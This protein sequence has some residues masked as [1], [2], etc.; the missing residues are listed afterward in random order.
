[1]TSL[2]RH[3]VF[4]SL[5]ICFLASTVGS[6]AWAIP[7]VTLSANLNELN[8][9]PYLGSYEDKESTENIDTIQHR[10][11]AGQFTFSNTENLNFGYTHSAYWL[12]TSIETHSSNS[13]LSVHRYVV[14]YDY[15]PIDFVDLFVLRDGQLEHHFTEGDQQ[16]TPNVSQRYRL[17]AFHLQLQPDQEY[18]LVFRISG[19]GS[20]QAPIS[21]W[22]EDSF[23]QSHTQ[24]LFFWGAFYG[25]L[26]VMLFYNSL[27]YLTV[28]SRSYLYYIVY[29]FAF[30]VFQSGFAGHSKMGLPPYY[31]AI[32]TQ[33]ILTGGWV[34]I[35]TINYFTRAFLQT[36]AHSHWAHLWLSTVCWLGT[37]LS[38][39][40]LF[41]SY[42]VNS[43]LLSL[44][45]L[46]TAATC[47]GIAIRSIYTGM[48]MATS[49][50]W[51]W[52]PFLVALVAEA[53]RN[54][55]LLPI[56]IITQNPLQIGSLLQVVM[57]SL[58]LAER[59][60]LS[61]KLREQ[62]LETQQSTE[63]KLRLREKELH[64]NAL[65]DPISGLPNKAMVT[66]AF[67]ENV[68]FNNK[69]VACILIFST[70]FQTV[71][72]TLGHESAEE[73][74]RLAA[75]RLIRLTRDLTDS[76]PIENQDFHPIRIASIEG[77]KFIVLMQLS[78]QEDQVRNFCEQVHEVLNSP[79]EINGL[80]TDFGASIGVARF[81]EHGRQF[82]RLL[83]H[84]HI[85]LD[86]AI[87]N[88]KLFSI[89]S[90]EHDTFTEQK[91]ALMVDLRKSIHAG[92]LNLVFQPQVQLETGQATGCE[93]LVR[94]EHPTRG[95]VSPVV[96]IPLAE[97]IGLI[98]SLT[99]WVLNE[100]FAF[101]HRR[102]QEG[103]PINLA[104]NLS[105]QDLIQ[106]DFCEI[107]IEL[108]SNYDFE[109]SRL[110]LEITESTMVQ[111]MRRS[112][113]T[114]TQI[115]EMGF[116]ISIDDFGT[117]YSSL[118]YLKQL[119]V[120]ELKIDRSFI[121]DLGKNPSDP[122]IP[123]IINMAHQLNL[124]IVAEGIE[125]E[126]EAGLLTEMGC[127]IGQGFYFATP[128]PEQDLIEWV[129]QHEPTTEPTDS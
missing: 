62:A 126:K 103:C 120:N 3:L 49:Y 20:L 114:L 112:L 19:E 91:L 28:R 94:W 61:D 46:I 56:N 50:L 36:R 107:L 97:Q 17:P 124:S 64:Y 57:L 37:I 106:D 79:F 117:G 125:T 18:Q 2:H 76:L 118:S 45:L 105:A 96:F 9:G 21:I 110:I 116:Q 40:S 74:I 31:E 42:F 84:A 88:N 58:A 121:T 32:F 16:I 29:I 6:K 51:A 48:P 66:A 102:H 47:F 122:F 14:E 27:I 65:H 25:I 53:M 108:S 10:F 39:G 13:D 72:N 4:Y 77:S 129:K 100:S 41:I 60:K 24:Q 33:H 1:M 95:N 93:A 35:T 44:Y 67:T 83:R 8:L 22:S 75:Y 38:V 55:G 30:L 113:V 68:V 109:R 70:N 59:I 11:N 115:R 63:Q 87:L 7:P 54:F 123:T 52:S 89:Y 43:Y 34:L 101:L 85:G 12:W 5:M 99:R 23:S 82:S 119:P 81:P 78:E 71:I 69:P 128:L 127:E 111:D 80:Q 73:M 86:N 15:A 92:D 98:H 26:A 90:M 104:V